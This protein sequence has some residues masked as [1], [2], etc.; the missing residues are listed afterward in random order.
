MQEEIIY[1]YPLWAIRELVFNAI[2]H[3]SYES[4]AP[5]LI[6]E[7]SDRIEIKN[8][9][10]LFGQVN[11]RNFP[12]VSDYRNMEIAESLKVLGY[13]N[14]FNFGIETAKKYLKE[15]NNPE[16]YF[17]LTLGTAFK[18]TIYINKVWKQ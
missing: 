16:P 3:R 13:V 1:N 6:H 5:I 2:I 4:N 11:I 14:K 10:F 18:V 15:N 17:D 12:Y 7:F 8:P 9:G